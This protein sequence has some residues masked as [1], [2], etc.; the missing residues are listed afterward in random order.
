MADKTRKKV[1]GQEQC[2]CSEDCKNPPLDNSP[3]CAE[4]IKFCPRQS[5]LSGYEPKFDPDL[6][7]KH[8]GVKNA[9]NC[10]AY[11]F[12]YRRL[13][14]KCTKDYCPVS[15]PQPGLK[16]G[17]PKWSKVKGKRCPDLLG[18]LFGDVP[19]LKM[20]SFENRCPKNSSKIALVVDEDEDYHFYRQ[21]SNG[22]WSHKPGSLAVKRVD[23]SD[24]PI[25]RP[26]RAL[27]LYKNKYKLKNPSIDLKTYHLHLSGERNF[28]ENDKVK[29]DTYIKLKQSKLDS[30]FDENDFIFINK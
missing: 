13:P 26:D 10:F 3:F 14:K 29:S 21:D 17:Y 23:A 12:D 8:E 5:R 15:F 24:R 30:M 27:Y 16:S 2:Q 1:K 22:Y 6:Y 25:I 19:D 9:Q 28:T 20:T 7:N 11:A 4:H 18:R